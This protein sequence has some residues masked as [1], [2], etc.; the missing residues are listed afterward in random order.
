MC[1][2]CGEFKF[3][4]RDFDSRKHDNLMNSIASRGNDSR[5][6]YKDKDVFLGHHRLA[7]IDTSDKSNQPMHIG[8]HII[9]F[10]LC[11]MHI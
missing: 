9:V 7:R 10:N 1:G 4:D 2:I 11:L 5:G 8:K 6:T 3:V